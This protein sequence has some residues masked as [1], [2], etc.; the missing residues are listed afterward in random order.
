MPKLFLGFGIL[1]LSIWDLEFG[2]LDL[3]NL[4]LNLG[5]GDISC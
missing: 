1:A 4:N 5:T 2:I 3:E